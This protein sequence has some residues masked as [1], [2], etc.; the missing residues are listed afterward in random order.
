MCIEIL[1]KISPNNQI[2]IQDRKVNLILNTPKTI[3]K[4]QKHFNIQK[5][6]N[7]QMN[8]NCLDIEIQKNLKKFSFS[9]YSL[10]DF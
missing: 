5:T 3:P 10:I 2:F 9:I 1:W 6:K 7:L 8:K 4:F